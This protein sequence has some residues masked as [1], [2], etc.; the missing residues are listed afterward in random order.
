MRNILSDRISTAKLLL[1]VFFS[2]GIA[3]MAIPATRDLFIS[4]T[5]LALLLSIAAVIFFHKPLDLKKEILFFV[6]IFLAGF[7]SR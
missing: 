1:A 7:S 3:G 4:L 5:P 6:F 2:V